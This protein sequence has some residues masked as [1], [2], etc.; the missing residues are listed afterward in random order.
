MGGRAYFVSKV[1]QSIATL[2]FVVAFNFFLFRVMPGDPVRLL[3][4]AQGLELSRQ[5]Q[6]DLIADLGLDKPLPAQFV[7]YLGD[8]LTGNLGES[9]IY[10]EPVTTIF[11]RFMWPTLLLV[12]TATVLMTVISTVAVPT[13]SSV[14]HMNRA[15]IVVTGSP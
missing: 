15:K 10:G 4:K 7:D 2:A 3:A 12:G 8:T 6:L 14:G 9:F 11:A 5:G 1:G 13:S